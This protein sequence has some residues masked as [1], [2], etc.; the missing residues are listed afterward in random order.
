MDRHADEQGQVTFA[1]CDGASQSRGK[2]NDIAIFPASWRESC[3]HRPPLSMSARQL[4][5]IRTW[6]G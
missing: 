6:R 2:L 3:H 4:N 5:V 1:D